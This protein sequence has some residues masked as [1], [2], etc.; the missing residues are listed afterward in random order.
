[1]KNIHTYLTLDKRVQ[2]KDNT[3]P[4]KIVVSRGKM[5]VLL[6]TGVYVLEKHWDGQ[7]VKGDKDAYRKNQILTTIDLGMKNYV[8]EC[9]HKGKL[10]ISRDEWKRVVEGIINPGVANTSSNDF[11]AVYED[12][13]RH[14]KGRTLELYLATRKKI[15]EY[16]DVVSFET[17]NKKWL[18]DFESWML[19]E[20]IA[21]NTI[22]IHMRN[23]RAIFNYALA[24]EMDIKYP[25]RSYKIKRAQTAKRSLTLEDISLLAH[26]P[27]EEYQEPYRALF[28]AIFYMRGINMVDVSR[29]TSKNIVG[30]RI[31]YVRSK[32]TKPYSI[33]IEPELQEL[34]DK[35][36]GE[37]HLFSIFDRY[38]DY[39]NVTK[40]FNDALQQVGSGQKKGRKATSAPLFP[41]IT[42]YTARHSWATIAYS[43]G[44]SMEVISD[45]LGHE[46][47]SKVTNIYIRKDLEEVDRWNR[48]I[49]DAL[50]SCK[51]V[52][53]E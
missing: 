40:H 48:K 14:K 28:L 16:T 11:D 19:D 50:N 25:F 43:L 32:T 4:V 39:R 12:F 44:A 9:Y 18:E 22:S 3:Y 35:W 34:L 23:I 45:A 49:I 42:S 33:K 21:V 10:P 20:G 27:V 13:L 47:G 41:Q 29:L 8:V 38:Q 24:L 36:K 52:K 1:M 53:L 15:A 6:S 37:S 7:K 46:Y 51:I 30:G 5:K 26:Y 2:K 31:E 17:I